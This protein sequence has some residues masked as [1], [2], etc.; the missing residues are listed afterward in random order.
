MTQ[1]EKKLTS[2]NQKQ[3]FSLVIDLTRGELTK[4][5]PI[6]NSIE[7]V[8]QFSISRI[9]QATDVDLPTTG[10]LLS[11]NLE[12]IRTLLFKQNLDNL[13]VLDDT[14]FSGSTSLLVEELLRKALPEK[15]IHFTHGFLILNT[16]NL[17][18]SPGAKERLNKAGST[19]V[20]SMEMTTP[21]D[22]G[23]HIFDM[24]NQANIEDHFLVVRE[25]IKLM[26]KPEFKQLA[27]SFL[28]IEDNLNLMFPQLFAKDELLDLQK[29]GHFIANITINGDFHVRNPQL[30]PN[31]IGQNHLISPEF[32]PTPATEAFALLI[33]INQLLKKGLNNEKN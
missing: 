15:N 17:G 18:K 6:L 20:A 9:R 13:L 12:E 22:D 32:W 25:I 33:H 2:L 28:A 10:H 29:T 24:I 30:L 27:T 7:Q 21:K 23:W 31:I 19:T 14:S 3:A 16:G 26:A 11:H 8:N 5:M 4:R 1:L